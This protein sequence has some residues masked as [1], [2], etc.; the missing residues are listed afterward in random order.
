MA[1]M[2]RQEA[3]ARARA[4]KAYR[5]QERLAEK[6]RESGWEVKPPQDKITTGTK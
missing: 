6:L 4:A 5:Y 1:T 3:A 2:T